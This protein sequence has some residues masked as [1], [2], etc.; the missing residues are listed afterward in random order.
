MGS[1]QQAGDRYVTGGVNWESYSLEDLVAMVAE[2]A[3]APQLE[4]L[5]DDWRAAGTEVTDAAA[6]LATA[7]DELMQYWSGA[8][9]EQARADVALN[10]Q[11]VGDLGETAHQI[12]DPVQ[13]AAG[14]LK[15]AQ[16]AMPA[17][18]PAPPVDPALAVDAAER[19]AIAGGPMAAA[20]N[21]TAAGADSAFAAQQE[22]TQLKAVAVEAMRRFEGAALGIDAATPRFEERETELRPRPD[23]PSVPLPPGWVPTVPVSYVTDV[24]L[25]W[26]E[27]TGGNSGTTAQSLDSTNSSGGGGSGG[28]GGY[29]GGAG[30]AAAVGAGGGGAAGAPVRGPLQS[31]QRTGITESFQNPVKAATPGPAL[32]PAPAAA[33]GGMA[34]GMPM[35]GGMGAGQGG[36]Q[37]EHRRRYPFDAED[38]FALEQKASPPVIGL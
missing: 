10:A 6:V 19:G 17:V 29:G 22:Q 34:G 35:G 7:L 38:P 5:A 24:E 13:E 4:R 14:A 12:G 27:L 37:G 11:W 36:D 32:H 8:A 33:H 26:L 3:S 30:A 31:G 18:P 2:N 1:G 23:T 20:I 28:G 21:A 15:A 9:A 16:D 25:R